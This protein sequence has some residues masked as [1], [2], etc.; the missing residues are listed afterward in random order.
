M[1]RLSVIVVLL[2]SIILLK[3]ED[4]FF[5]RY[6]IK[7]GTDLLKGLI[8]SSSTKKSTTFAKS[9]TKSKFD[10]SPIPA[11]N[12]PLNALTLRGLILGG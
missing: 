8:F 2:T 4:I 6:G 9:F 5:Q 10:I 12:D 7:E 11:T 3:A 1:K